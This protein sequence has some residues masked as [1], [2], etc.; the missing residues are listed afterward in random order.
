MVRR[1]IDDR[2]RD[3]GS[4]GGSVEPNVV[5]WGEWLRARE[6]TG[7]DFEGQIRGWKEKLIEAAGSN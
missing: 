3:M 7:R 1:R 2:L 6:E 4:S 5:A